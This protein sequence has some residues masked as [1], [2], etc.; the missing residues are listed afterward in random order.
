MPNEALASQTLG[1]GA[2]FIWRHSPVYLAPAAKWLAVCRESKMRKIAFVA[3]VAVLLGGIAYAAVTLFSEQNSTVARCQHLVDQLK[4][5]RLDAS[6]ESW[7][8]EHRSKWEASED[9]PLPRIPLGKGHFTVAPPS[10]MLDLGI[11]PNSEAQVL[12]SKD[13]IAT[14]QLVD[15][16]AQSI[17]ISADPDRWYGWNVHN[18]RP[19]SS[20]VAVVCPVRD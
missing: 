5:K 4:E 8:D 3:V 19:V 6:L 15:S 12:V 2:Q 9:R 18:L 13:A 11:G 14:V 17:I 1:G 10:F 20:R 16:D 7:F